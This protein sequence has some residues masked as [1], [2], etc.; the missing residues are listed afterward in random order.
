MQVVADAEPGHRKEKSTV[1]WRPC[2]TRTWTTDYYE[3]I[4]ALIVFVSPKWTV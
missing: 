1:G 3:T 4:I 2:T